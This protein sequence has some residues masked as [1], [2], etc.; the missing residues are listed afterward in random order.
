MFREINS[1][2]YCDWPGR[3]ATQGRGDVRGPLFCSKEAR[4]FS[5]GSFLLRRIVATSAKGITPQ[6]AFGCAP[7]TANRPI[8]ADHFDRILAAGRCVPATRRK[9][10]ADPDLIEA[11]QFD[12]HPS[13]RSTDHVCPFAHTHCRA[14][15]NIIAAGDFSPCPCIQHLFVGHAP[16]DGH[17]RPDA[18]AF[19]SR[20]DRLSYNHE[21]EF[22]VEKTAAAV[23][24]LD[25]LDESN[26]RSD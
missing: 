10:R 7:A 22:F 15:T 24:C 19:G 9:H 20:G 8:F 5:G 16:H 14:S 2:R 26:D 18:S 1:S 11:N 13:D 12:H 4:F 25:R 23:R 17:V 21:T 3:G 6:D